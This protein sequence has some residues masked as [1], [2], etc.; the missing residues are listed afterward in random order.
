M[1]FLSN[2]GCKMS[3]C[4]LASAGFQLIDKKKHWLRDLLVQV[5]YCPF[6]LWHFC[7]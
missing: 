2:F 5:A 3:L 6:M 7:C 1:R 4:A